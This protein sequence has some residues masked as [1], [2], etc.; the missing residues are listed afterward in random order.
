M[1]IHKCGK[2][3]V[4]WGQHGAKYHGKDAVAKAVKQAQAAY[5]NG[6]REKKGK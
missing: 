4:Q 6:Y 3:C 5:A 1:P 2:G